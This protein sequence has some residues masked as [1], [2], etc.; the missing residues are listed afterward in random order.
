MSKRTP[1]EWQQLIEQQQASGLTAAE[2]CRQQNINTKY[3]Y[4]RR[5]RLSK[6]NNDAA[7]VIAKP[8]KEIA[9][10]QAVNMQLNIGACGLTFNTPPQPQ[11]L[12]ELIKAL[13]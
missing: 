7:F 12:A 11:W 2:F 8:A 3:F 13:A 4:L 1:A 5:Q 10:K 9:D 6:I